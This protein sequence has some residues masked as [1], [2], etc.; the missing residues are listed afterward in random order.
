MELTLQWLLEESELVGLKLLTCKEHLGN[1]ISGVNIMDN[2]DTVRWIKPG[3]L[4]LTTG[5]VFREN[6]SLQESTIAD[7]RKAGCSALCI[8]SKRFLD[9]IPQPMLD[10]SQKEGLLS[11]NYLQIILLPI[12]QKQYRNIFFRNSF[13]MPSASR[14]YLILYLIVI[15]RGALWVRF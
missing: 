12:F 13:K 8:K 14:H 4:V 3:E 2:P 7:L 9:E 10:A 15:F 6:P 5:Y 1:I 11:L